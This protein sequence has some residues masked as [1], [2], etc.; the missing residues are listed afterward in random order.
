MRLP[1]RKE[2]TMISQE[3]RSKALIEINNAIPT[4]LDLST[5]D[6]S[7]ILRELADNYEKVYNS[8]VTV[9]TTSLVNFIIT[10]DIKP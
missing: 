5:D 10:G 2:T 9:P 4:N 7:S 3:T 6:V 8:H 1:I